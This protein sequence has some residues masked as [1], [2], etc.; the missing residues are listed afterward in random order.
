MELDLAPEVCVSYLTRSLQF[1]LDEEAQEGLRIFLELALKH[2]FW[3]KE[4]VLGVPP[5]GVASPVRLEFYNSLS[6][7]ASASL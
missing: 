7:S 3:L 6:E 2:H 1:R 4:T 5:L